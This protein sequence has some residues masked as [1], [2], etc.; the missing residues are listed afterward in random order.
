MQPRSILK[1]II[2]VAPLA[3][4]IG[5]G[6]DVTVDPPKPKPTDSIHVTI[7]PTSGTMKVGE[8]RQFTATVTGTSTTS[9]SWIL[10][11]SAPD[12]GS[13]SPT[14]LYT[15][16]AGIVGDSI[17][18]TIT[19]A[20][21]VTPEALATA[22][23]VVRR[24]I[25]T[26]PGAGSSYDYTV[27]TLDSVGHKIAGS[28]RTLTQSVSETGISWKEKNDVMV[29]NGGE[30]PGYVRL[31]SNG[32]LSRWDSAGSWLLYPFGSRGIVAFPK[33]DITKPSGARYTDSAVATYI[34]A[35]L[36]KVGDRT[37]AAYK[38]RVNR[39][40]TST[41]PEP[42]TVAHTDNYWYAPEIGWFIKWDSWT[43]STD[44]TSVTKGGAV[45]TLAGFDLK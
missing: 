3:L 30:M 12:Y 42:Y 25:P 22:T 11:S 4:I 14:G 40:E 21:S 16:P 43:V 2:L 34:G 29:I 15:A 18:V 13:I 35:E 31:E 10:H 6:K 39:V 41:A 26:Q 1:A 17:T 28:E 9:V 8:S 44:M 23:V 37:F 38:V 7:E 19:A 20:S 5:C 45:Y 36:V 27:S 24:L 32:D 33:T